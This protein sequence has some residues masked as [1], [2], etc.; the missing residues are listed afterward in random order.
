MTT[1]VDTKV[2]ETLKENDTF[3]YRSICSIS[4]ASRVNSLIPPAPNSVLCRCCG[5][6]CLRN[7]KISIALGESGGG[8]GG[9]K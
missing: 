2:V 8:G 3:R 5:L 6:H 4:F 1:M 7:R 9:G